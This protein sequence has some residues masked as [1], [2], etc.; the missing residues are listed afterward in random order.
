MAR[1]T[2]ALSTAFATERL[3]RVVNFVSAETLAHLQTEADAGRSH[4]ERSYIPAY[5]QGGTLS[6]ERMHSLAPH[7]LGVYHSEAMRQWISAVVGEDVFPTCDHDQ[8][9]CLLLYYD[10]EGDHIGWHYDQ[11]FYK[12]RRFTVLLAVQNAAAD[13]G[14]ASGH[15][16]HRRAGGEIIPVDTSPNVLVLFEGMRVHHCVTPVAKGD[17]RVMLSLTYCTDPRLG[18]VQEVVR[19]FKDVGFY[20]LRALWD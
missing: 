15:L 18:R 10:R 11:N 4:V 3:V 19:R 8:S 5:K 17:V 2:P 13:G 12:G 1:P 7:G 20:G 6:Y 9:S 16:Q 14:V